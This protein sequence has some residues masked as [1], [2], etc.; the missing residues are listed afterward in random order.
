MSIKT[1]PN[2]LRLGVIEAPSERLVCVTAHIIG[3]SQSETNYQSGVGEFLS[4]ML[5]CGTQTTPGKE[6]LER[7]VKEHGI[8][9]ESSC[10]AEN[11]LLTAVCESDKAPEAIEILSDILF[12]SMFSSTDATATRNAMLG[13]IM[14]LSDSSSYVLSKL[15]NNTMFPRTGL[16]NPRFGTTTTISRMRAA[17]AKEYLTKILTPKNTIISVAGNVD[18]DEIYD[19]VMRQFY[20]RFVENTEYK[21]LKYVAKV[22]NIKQN[23]VTRNKK[24]NQSRMLISFPCEDYRNV[25]RHALTIALPILQKHMEES[26]SHLDFYHTEKAFIKRYAYNGRLSFELVVDSEKTV[27]YL[28]E[29]VAFLKEA[30]AKMTEIEF[31]LEKNVYITS[32]LETY[33]NVKNLS[34]AQAREI[35]INKQVFSVNSEIL[36]ASMMHVED[37]KDLLDNTLDMSK[38]TF[39]YLGLPLGEDE[40]SNIINQ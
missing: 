36:N 29:L 28:N 5:L 21:K 26:L 32:L 1:F 30:T 7:R 35:A 19:L 12:N 17:D 38:A 23:I 2:G 10:G 24:Y 37:A 22:D 3:G 14:N 18:T 4:R 13:D 6:E 20:T 8:I 9:L 40:I 33:D 25:K 16:A 34:V 11:I 31:E 15:T 27:E 39:V